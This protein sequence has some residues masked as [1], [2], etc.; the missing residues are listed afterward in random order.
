MYGR[1]SE[2]PGL[3]WHWRGRQKRKTVGGDGGRVGA[4]E[5]AAQN[6]GSREALGVTSTL[7]LLEIG[8]GRQNQPE[9]EGG[10]SASELSVHFLP[11]FRN[12]RAVLEKCQ[13]DAAS[14]SVHR[15]LDDRKAP[16]TIQTCSG[17]SR[18]SRRGVFV[19]RL[20][21]QM[22]THRHG[23]NM[24]LR[25]KTQQ[26]NTAQE[27]LPPTARSAEN[28]HASTSN[29]GRHLAIRTHKLSVNARCMRPHDGR[30][31]AHKPSPR[32]KGGHGSD[33]TRTTCR[34]SDRPT[35]PLC[36]TRW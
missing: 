10:H 12:P 32:P 31:A 25:K 11:E 2:L 19:C 14:E 15:M 20:C 27:H 36:C 16:N 3:R 23:P 4:S 29:G 6:A 24:S 30:P 7:N 5:R 13:E 8:H 1:I 33:N 21:G 22:L 26:K 28:S 18:H 17:R 9:P 35:T 34:A